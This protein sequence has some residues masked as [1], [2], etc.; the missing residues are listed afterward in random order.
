MKKVTGNK[1]VNFKI[2]TLGQGGGNWNGS[3][4]LNGDCGETRDKH[5]LAKLRG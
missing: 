3:T 5:N 2:K 4:S 1:S